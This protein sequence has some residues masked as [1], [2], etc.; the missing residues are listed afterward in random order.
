MSKKQSNPAFV[1]YTG[2]N[3]GRPKH[4][5]PDTLR[6]V[7]VYVQTWA[8]LTNLRIS[9]ICSAKGAHLGWVAMNVSGFKNGVRVEHQVDQGTLRRR[10]YEA[11]RFLKAESEPYARLRDMGVTSSKFDEIS[12]TEKWWRRLRDENI[13]WAQK[14]SGKDS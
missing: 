10:Y 12:P 11:V 4:F 5:D 1:R 7:W 9:K 14:L 13:V 6:D 2:R 3:V 8:A